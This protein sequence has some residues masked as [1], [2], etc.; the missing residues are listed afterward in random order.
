MFLVTRYLATEF[1]GTLKYEFGGDATTETN[2]FTFSLPAFFNETDHVVSPNNVSVRSKK[3]SSSY[4]LSQHAHSDASNY[5]SHGRIPREFKELG[6]KSANRSAISLSPIGNP[7]DFSINSFV[8]SESQKSHIENYTDISTRSSTRFRRQGLAQMA[9]SCLAEGTDHNNDISAN[10]PVASVLVVDDAPMNRRMLCRLIQPLVDSATE[11]CDGL[12]AVNTLKSALNSDAP[13]DLIL[14]DYQMPNMDGP[15]AAQHMREMGYKGL[16]I[17][18]TGNTQ[19]SHIDT[20]L[21]FGADAV[22]FKP[23]QLEDLHRTMEGTIYQL[24]L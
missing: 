3:P 19:Q 21:S 17:G 16:I 5:K 20:F 24:P 10:V 2:A 8:N 11:A 23:L 9:D 14:M 13:F 1:H 7:R 6:T 12:E 15:T 18:V 22:L 4:A